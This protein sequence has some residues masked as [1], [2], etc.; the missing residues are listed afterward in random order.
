MKYWFFLPTYVTVNSYSSQAYL[1]WGEGTGGKGLI[2]GEIRF[3]EKD[4]NYLVNRVSIRSESHL[5]CYFCRQNN[6][7]WTRKFPK[8]LWFCK[9]YLPD[10]ERTCCLVTVLLHMY[11][12]VTAYK[13]FEK[14][15]FSIGLVF[16]LAE[17]F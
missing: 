5:I 11:C 2:R 14:S 10:I 8:T 16:R 6:I 13:A 1:P 15:L 4:Y 3:M 17:N 9:N 12:L 7:F